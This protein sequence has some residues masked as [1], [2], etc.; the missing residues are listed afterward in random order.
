MKRRAST[1]TPTRAR[2]FPPSLRT[3]A[4][5]VATG[6]PSA[7]LPSFHPRSGEEPEPIGGL[8]AA[9]GGGTG[10]AGRSARATRSAA[11]EAV[12]TDTLKITGRR[13][14]ARSKTGITE[15]IR[16]RSSRAAAFG[17]SS[18]SRKADDPV[19]RPTIVSPRRSSIGTG[20]RS[21]GTGLSRADLV[22]SATARTESSTRRA[23][24]SIHSARDLASSG[25]RRSASET[26]I[27]ASCRPDACS[28]SVNRCSSRMTKAAPGMQNARRKP[29]S[30]RDAMLRRGSSRRQGAVEPLTG[31][32]RPPDE[33]DGLSW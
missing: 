11:P 5:T 33:P 17:A 15:R 2:S 13:S 16:T 22:E 1:S 31:G 28:S 21:S 25:R 3:A 27:S 12:S 14:R 32:T 20:G 7:L 30:N 26:R 9:R 29:S 6:R 10:L 18:E 24:R 4:A 23:R 19:G 8:A